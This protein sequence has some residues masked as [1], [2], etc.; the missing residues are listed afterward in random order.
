MEIYQVVIIFI[1]GLGLGAVIG[2]NISAGVKKSKHLNM[3]LEK[4]RDEMNAYRN[5]V[6][7]HFE[8]SA[9]LIN[10]MTAS[11]SSL[12]EHLATSSQELC[13]TEAIKLAGATV[14]PHLLPISEQES[15]S[16]KD[17]LETAPKEDIS[18]PIDSPPAD[19]PETEA[20][21]VKETEHP[22]PEQIH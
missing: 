21:K 19:G 4:S 15:G 20:K 22:A 14:P 7:S 2:R 13:D 5:K 16:E 1:A 12:Y 17:S 9:N 3:E 10:T 8:K 11:Y 18:K 6:E